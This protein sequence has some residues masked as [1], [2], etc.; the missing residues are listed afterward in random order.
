MR[1]REYD[2]DGTRT[3]KRT[4]E[5]VRFVVWGN[6]VVVECA[7]VNGWNATMGIPRQADG[8]MVWQ[9]FTGRNQDPLEIMDGR[10]H[11]MYDP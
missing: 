6:L 7:A 10:L 3:T 9:R 4:A 5:V 8:L 11:R 1:N 2:E